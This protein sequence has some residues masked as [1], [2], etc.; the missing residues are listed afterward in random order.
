VLPL[1]TD[2]VPDSLEILDAW[3]EDG[4]PLGG[5]IRTVRP[6][7]PA[8]NPVSPPVLAEVT[9]QGAAPGPLLRV[10]L[11]GGDLADTCAVFTLD[12]GGQVLSGGVR[13]GEEIVLDLA[14]PLAAGTYTLRLAPACLGA[15]G[16]ERGFRVG[17]VFYPNPIRGAAELTVEGLPVGASVRIY[18]ARGEERMSWQVE[19]PAEVRPVD[20]PPGLYFVRFEGGGAS[21]I[22]KLVVLR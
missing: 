18:D 21:G 13:I 5:S 8:P 4:Y 14:Q 1:G 12:P 6:V 19:G 7:P 2:D 20:L 15:G 9:Y 16:G 10:R 11:G 22:E 3:E 17:A